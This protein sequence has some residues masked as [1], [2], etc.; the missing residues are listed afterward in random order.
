MQLS[1][2][3]RLYHGGQFYKWRKPEYPEKTTDLSQVTDKLYQIMLYRVHLVL[4]GFKLLMLIVIGT[5]R[6]RY[7]VCYKSNYHM[8]TTM[9]PLYTLNIYNII[10]VILLNKLLSVMR[11]QWNENM[12]YWIHYTDK[13]SKSRVTSWT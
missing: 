5:D 3:F 2:I 9:I 10:Y 7:N 1:T 6:H 8:I 13:F 11:T 12:K 4:V